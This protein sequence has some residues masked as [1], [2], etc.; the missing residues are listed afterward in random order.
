MNKQ[1]KTSSHS[2]SIDPSVLYFGTPVALI[3]S[4]NEDG[5][6]NLSPMSSVWSLGNRLI[7]GLGTDGHAYANLRRCPECVVNLPSATLVNQVETIAP[8][9]GSNPV[10]KSKR[11]NGYRHEADKFG[12]SGLTAV[13]S[14][15]VAP[16]RA[17]ECP[18]QIEAQMLHSRSFTDVP[19]DDNIGAA[20][21][22]VRVE[23][24][25]A[26]EDI[27]IEGTDYIDQEQWHPLLY[28]WRHYYTTGHRLGRNFRDQT[29]DA[30]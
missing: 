30:V 29:P 12:L 17:A 27:A 19:Q 25:H 8:T 4:L 1:T 20:I 9:T 10:P 13:A 2:I 22:E 26:H 15:I 28:V 16:A 11:L 7:L 3:S 21:V 14:D 24:V 5:T 6:T 18:L 23:R